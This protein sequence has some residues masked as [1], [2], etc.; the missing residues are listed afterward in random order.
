MRY[1][2]VALAAAGLMLQASGAFAITF[3]P[4]TSPKVSVEAGAGESAQRWT[5]GLAA[6]S[7]G[8]S[9]IDLGQSAKLTFDPQVRPLFMV[10]YQAT[11]K[12]S[13]GGWYNAIGWDANF[14]MNGQSVKLAD[15]DGSVWEVHGTYL[16]P[17]GFAAQLAFLREA[18]TIKIDPSVLAGGA[19]FDAATNYLAL[20]GTK[21]FDWKK[22]DGK[23]FSAMAGLGVAQV[24]SEDNKDNAVRDISQTALHAQVGGSYAFSPRISADASL[25]L[26]DF[27][28]DQTVSRFTFGV[29]GRF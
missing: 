19:D 18:T 9:D 11:N 24:L 10:D 14:E 21:S 6:S 8:M 7:W 22:E 26:N 27:T 23:G 16:L 4:P 29:T 17:Q 12:I 20:W 28:A 25:W 13:V 5:L 1:F 15:V 3:Q 2:S